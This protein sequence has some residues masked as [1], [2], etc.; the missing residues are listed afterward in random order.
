[1]S[2]WVTHRERWGNDLPAD[3]NISMFDT[4]GRLI[5][6]SAATNTASLAADRSVVLA[7]GMVSKIVA[8]RLYT[9]VPVTHEGRSILGIIQV[10]ASLDAVNARL[11]ARWLALSGA[12]G[13]ALLLAFGIALW[14][15]ARLTR[16]LS[17]LRGVAQQMSEGQLD[18]RVRSATRPKS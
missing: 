2:A 8:G 4:Q 10:D 11:T 13:A 15:A 6:G 12:A 7:G 16:P 14:L 18:A 9:A 17:E 5:A 3:A 1:M